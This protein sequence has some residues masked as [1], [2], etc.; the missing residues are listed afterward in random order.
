[1]PLCELAAHIAGVALVPMD[2]ADPPA[3]MRLLA[4]EAAPALLL[5]SPDCCP[6]IRD[7]LGPSSPVTV[8]DASLAIWGEAGEPRR[9][10]GEALVTGERA[11]TPAGA[12]AEG[13]PQWWEGGG[14]GSR[15][16]HVFYTSGSTG[17]PK[18]CLV[19]H[20]S[21]AQY[22]L[23]K[24]HVHVRRGPAPCTVPRPLPASCN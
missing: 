8:L 14:A 2:P 9:A 12:R 11:T 10:E 6:R 22:C 1:M 20:A 23:S 18:G 5:A 17:R 4:D 16:S 21:L 7:A 24:N 19:E 3:R 13:K 15:L